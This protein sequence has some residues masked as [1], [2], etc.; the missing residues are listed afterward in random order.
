MASDTFSKY[1]VKMCYMSQKLF[2]LFGVEHKN[3]KVGTANRDK[4]HPSYD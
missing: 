3:K 2:H 4:L 1:K